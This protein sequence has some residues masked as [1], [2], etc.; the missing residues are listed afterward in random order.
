MKAKIL[1]LL[2]VGLLVGP[3]LQAN[4]D[5]PAFLRV[6]VH[7]NFLT[8]VHSWQS[9]GAFVDSGVLGDSV[10]RWVG[11]PTPRVQ[12]TVE[13]VSDGIVATD[14]SR[15]Y[16]Q[17][18]ALHFPTDDPVILVRKAQWHIYDGTDRYAGL[19]GEGD[20]DGTVNLVTGELVDIFTGWVQLPS[21]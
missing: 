18:N 2:A 19:K 6:E 17:F 15:I 8:G 10:P 7:F 20:L 11:N 9:T 12:G 13:K 5:A 4:A 1:G 21:E 3:V 14:G 16:W